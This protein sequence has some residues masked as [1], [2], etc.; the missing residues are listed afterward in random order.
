MEEKRSALRQGVEILK[1]QID[2]L[3]LENGKLKKGS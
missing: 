1:G 3:Q 2:R